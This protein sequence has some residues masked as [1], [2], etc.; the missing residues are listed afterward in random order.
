M[1]TED[2]EEVKLKKK[3]SNNDYNDFYTSFNEM[4]E[5]EG[6]KESKK[7]SKKKTKKEE[8]VEEKDEDDYSD[9]YGSNDEEENEPVKEGNGNKTI[10]RFGIIILLVIILAVLLVI[11]LRKGEEEKG[12][13]ELSKSAYE[14]K[15]GDKDY[16]S[17]TVVDTEKNVTSTFTSSNPNVVTVDANGELTAVGKGEATITVSYTING[18][19]REKQCNVVVSGPDIKH[20]LSLDLKASTTNWT[21]K[22]V[23]ITVTPK[24]DTTITSLKYAIN[25]SGTCTYNNV[26]NN[27]IVISN[28]GTT[29]VVVVAKDQSNLEVTK[30]ITTK[31]DKEAP[32]V[33]FNGSKNITSNKDVS[34]CVTCSDKLSGCKQNKVCKKYTSSK[35]NQVIT[36]TDN[37]GNSKNSPS[38]NV[39]INKVEA[40]CTLKVS[41]DGTVSATLKE[42]PVY[43]GFNSSY[44][45][46]NELSKKVTVGE[47]GKSGA[48]VVYYYIKS[49]NGN[50]GSCHITV[51]KEC[52]NSTCTYRA[53]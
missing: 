23:T 13:I 28:S 43:Y 24:T 25:C 31:I 35:S 3:D 44:S 39:T 4:E 33:T 11:L 20:E 50:T 7:E 21:N 15:I 32:T 9:F 51:V 5:N 2:D 22:D 38:F 14:L 19:T 29:K 27:K 30:E 18:K 45:G 6:K 17:Y 12:D 41:S 1:Y 10:I 37:A 36:V 40:P 46:S 49:K 47:N 8:I 16:V 34:V 53:N 48:K 52:K 26:T 42:T